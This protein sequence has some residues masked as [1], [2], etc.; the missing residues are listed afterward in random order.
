MS[1]VP[2]TGVDN[3]KK[4]VTFAAALISKEDIDH[5]KWV[6]DSFLQ[7]MGRQPVC[8]VTD[9]CPALKQAVPAVLTSTKHRFCMW[10]IMNKFATKVRVMVTVRIHYK[11]YMLND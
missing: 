1:F 9:Q 4:S 10:H 8:I 5:Y 6:F 11:Y 7:A 2:F 3:H